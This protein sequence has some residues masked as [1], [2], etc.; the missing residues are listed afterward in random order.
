MF[1]RNGSNNGNESA[2]GVHKD[3]AP[4]SSTGQAI[5]ARNGNGHKP[6]APIVSEHDL[7]WDGLSPAVTRRSDS[8]SNPRWSPSARGAAASPTTTS[9]ATSSSSRP[10]ASSALA[11][12]ATSWSATSPCAGSRRSMP[13]RAR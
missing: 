4:V 2:N 8:P 9:K 13:R 10:T 12:G 5:A 1:N 7:L 6:D 11:G 3:T